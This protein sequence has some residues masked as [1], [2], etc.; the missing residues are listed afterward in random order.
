MY[1]S[2]YQ[3]NY[4]QSLI[5]TALSTN[6]MSYE[7]D[8]IVSIFYFLLLLILI[9][10]SV[11]Y[12]YKPSNNLHNFSNATDG[13]TITQII[14]KGPAKWVFSDLLL[15]AICSVG[16]I[17][18]RSIEWYYK[19]N[20]LVVIYFFTEAKI[21]AFAPMSPLS[22]DLSDRISSRD[23]GMA[24]FVGQKLEEYISKQFPP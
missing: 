19:K 24:Y 4:L 14:A 7:L 10:L 18:Y 23:C 3:Q 5:T 13:P 6:W 20:R 1:G 9:L 22:K 12:Y 21:F 11:N 17:V 15:I 2:E 16:F 8:K